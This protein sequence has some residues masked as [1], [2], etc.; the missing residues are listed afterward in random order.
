MSA[1]R[2]RDLAER[3]FDFA[4]DVVT[5]CRELSKEPGVVRQISWQ[6]SDAATSSAANYEEAKAAYSRR[7]FAARN[8]VVLKELRE[9]KLWIRIVIRCR[10]GPPIEA[11]RLLGEAGELCA[12]FTSSMK[13]LHPVQKPQP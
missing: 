8:S 4:C 2:P 6:L 13:K 10:L 7:D 9:S 12:I 3:L 1:S 5:Y 11:T